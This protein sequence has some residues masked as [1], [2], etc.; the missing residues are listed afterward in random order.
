MTG[1]AP[2]IG[3]LCEIRRAEQDFDAGIFAVDVFVQM[4]FD[5]A[6]VVQ[7]QAFTECILRNL[8]ASVHVS[9]KGGREVESDR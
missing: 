4:R 5:D 7:S 1:Q 3:R 6:V 2:P 9:P 8:E